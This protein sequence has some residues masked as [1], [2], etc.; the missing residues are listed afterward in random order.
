MAESVTIMYPGHRQMPSQMLDDAERYGVST[1]L[2]CKGA[3]ALLGSPG[4]AVVGSRHT[5]TEGIQAAREISL[6]L[7]SRGMNIVSGY[8]RGVDQEAHNAALDAGGTTTMVLSYGIQRLAVGGLLASGLEDARCLAVSPFPPRS[9]WSAGAAMA[10]NKLVCLLSKAVVV[11]ASG[12]KR[13]ASGR[14]SGTFH[15]AESAREMGRQVFVLDPSYFDE[16]PEGNVAL[17]RAGA[18]P[19]PPSYSSE[20]AP[21]LERIAGSR[22]DPPIQPCLFQDE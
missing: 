22:P 21:V 17:L 14:M 18:V 3:M 8:A 16:P 20:Y 9:G 12:R 15:A 4:V 5:P 6:H 1:V 19:I 13:D 2:Q 7:V 11:V 10:R